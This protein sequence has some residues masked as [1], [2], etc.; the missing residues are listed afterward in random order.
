MVRTDEAASPYEEGMP[1]Q[2][3][4]LDNG[5]LWLAHTLLTYEQFRQVEQRITPTFR[6][7]TKIRDYSE[8]GGPYETGIEVGVHPEDF[9]RVAAMFHEILAGR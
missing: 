2:P 1:M 8:L 9:G 4:P 5:Y 7:V 6:C 3:Q